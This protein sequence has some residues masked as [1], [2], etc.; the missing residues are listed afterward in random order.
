ME[1]MRNII[2]IFVAWMCFGMAV[3][4]Y[5]LG[6]TGITV[7]GMVNQSILEYADEFPEEVREEVR[8]WQRKHK[9]VDRAT[10]W[11][12]IFFMA[13]TW[14]MMVLVATVERD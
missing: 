7:R 3:V 6:R 2:L 11:A 12:W 13:L 4:S 8:E 9:F 5:L 14:P 1:L 10:S